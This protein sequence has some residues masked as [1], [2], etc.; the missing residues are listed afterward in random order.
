MKKNITAGKYNHTDNGN[1]QIAIISDK[2]QAIAFI[3]KKHQ[4]FKAN[5]KAFEAL[6]ELIDALLNANNA[7][8]MASLI[9]KST[10][11]YDAQLICEKAL[12]KALT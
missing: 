7:L 6:P 11:C 2:L 10:T 12:E 9:D 5:L 4:D 1:G 3:P 8:K